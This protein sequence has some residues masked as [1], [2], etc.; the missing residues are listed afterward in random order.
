MENNLTTGTAKER[1]YAR[2][3]EQLNDLLTDIA[4]THLFVETLETRNSDSLD[5]KDCAV[6]CIKDALIAAY[7][8]GRA[9]AERK[10]S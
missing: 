3:H 10:K 6:W 1:A 2:K 9:A 5:F 8:A 7:A 4:K